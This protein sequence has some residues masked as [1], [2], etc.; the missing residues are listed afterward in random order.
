MDRWVLVSYVVY[1]LVEMLAS[2][3][4]TTLGLEDSIQHQGKM[5]CM[6]GGAG[7]LWLEDGSIFEYR[8]LR[9][10]GALDEKN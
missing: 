4:H 3:I 2:C 5:H 9:C 10:M 6:R 7:R 1:D 8:L